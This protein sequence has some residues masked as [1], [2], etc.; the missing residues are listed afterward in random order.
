M[1]ENYKKIF[2]ASLMIRGMQ[3]KTPV[4]YYWVLV[5]V[6]IVRKHK[7]NKSRQWGREKGTL[8]PI[9]RNVNS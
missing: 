3:M 8:Q 2:G 5:I 1:D 6:N 4:K 7:Q 9:T